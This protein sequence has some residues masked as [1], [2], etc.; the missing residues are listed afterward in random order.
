MFGDFLFICRIKLSR[1][2]CLFSVTDCHLKF[3]SR[4]VSRQIKRLCF[5]KKKRVKYKY[6]FTTIKMG[7]TIFSLMKNYNFH[8]GSNCL[9]VTCGA[10]YPCNKWFETI[11]ELLRLFLLNSCHKGCSDIVSLTIDLNLFV[12]FNLYSHYK[13]IMLQLL[14]MYY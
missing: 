14:T 6:N 10:E 7:Y 4:Y 8:G 11:L 5:Q 9:C 3:P 12:S 2:Y 1:L 13:Q